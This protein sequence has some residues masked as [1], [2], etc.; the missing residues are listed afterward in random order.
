[1]RVCIDHNPQQVWHSHFFRSRPQTFHGTTLRAQALIH[2]HGAFYL[3]QRKWTLR[4]LVTKGGWV[5][6]EDRS[7]SFAGR[8]LC[9][10]WGKRLFFFCCFAL[11]LV[12]TSIIHQNII[13]PKILSPPLTDMLI[14]DW[15]F[16]NDSFPALS[17]KHFLIHHFW[18]NHTYPDI[19]S[20]SYLL[21]LFQ[22]CMLYIQ[23]V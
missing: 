12:M 14:S 1:M 17:Q 18:L 22:V 23:P 16:T 10:T 7:V 9:S 2:T 21:W 13:S 4:S 19:F 6:L 3:P 8:N 20:G 11:R 15:N 5:S